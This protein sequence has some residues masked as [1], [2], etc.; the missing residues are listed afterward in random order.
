M[1][2]LHAHATTNL[3]T[4]SHPPQPTTTP[5]QSGTRS[6]RRNQNG[7]PLSVLDTWEWQ[8]LSNVIPPAQ[9]HETG[10]LS[11]ESMGKSTPKIM[12]VLLEVGDATDFP[13]DI[14]FASL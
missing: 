8:N 13:N 6:V 2:L 11:G 7:F 1:L 12:Q 4:P 3:R 14:R 10:K 5:M 9:E